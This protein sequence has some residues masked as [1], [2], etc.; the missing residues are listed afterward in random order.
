MQ[1]YL[2]QS[3]RF[4]KVFFGL[5]CSLLLLMLASSSLNTRVFGQFPGNGDADGD[6]TVTLA[7]IVL[8]V[9]QWLSSP[10]GFVDQYPEGKI[11]T[12]DYAVVRGNLPSPGLTCAQ[13]NGAVCTSIALLTCR[14]ANWLNADDTDFCCAS[15]CV[16]NP[17][18]SPDPVTGKPDDCVCQIHP[19][20]DRFAV[21]LRGGGELDIP[22][23]TTAIT[24]YGQTAAQHT[25]KQFSGIKKFTGVTA[26]EL[27]SFVRGLYLNESVGSLVVVGND[28]PVT[29]IEFGVTRLDLNLID[30]L[31]YIDRSPYLGTCRDIGI[32]FVVPRIYRNT[33]YSAVSFVISTFQNFTA[34]HADIDGK[35]SAFKKEALSLNWDNTLEDTCGTDLYPVNIQTIL[36]QT[37]IMNSQHQTFQTLLEQKFGFQ[38]HL[39]HGAENLQGLGLTNFADGD[40]SC[41]SIYVTTDQFEQYANTHPQQFLIVHS[42]ACRSGTLGVESN[43]NC[44]FPQ[45]FL[46]AGTWAYYYLGGGGGE[47]IKAD[48]VPLSGSNLSDGVRK[49]STQTIIF[50][51]ILAGL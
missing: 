51:D 7:D 3:G 42:W 14:D 24:S 25:G 8:V 2:P 34:Y 6:G 28:L 12:L 50:G 17:I 15:E 41:G 29:M 4:L 31:T 22:T 43:L 21:L 16:A 44:C 23:V 36:P 27:V 33:S 20:K 40:R 35:R 5:I 1:Q 18:C 11:N 38:S 10:A 46:E 19:R 48:N 26:E 9:S 30:T 39:V 13:Q 47:I 32:S 37:S 45:K 49:Y